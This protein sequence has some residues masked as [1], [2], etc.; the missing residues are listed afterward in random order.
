MQRFFF[1][2]GLVWAVTVSGVEAQTANAGVSGQSRASA[3]SGQARVSAE[4][5]QD[6]DA[7]VNRKGKSADAGADARQQGR[8]EA[9]AGQQSLNLDAGTQINA[10]LKSTLDSRQA[11]DGQQFLLKTARDVKAG[12]RTV[13]RKGAT[14]VG[15]VV[16]AQSKAEGE[17][18]SSLTVMIDGVRQGEETIPLQ[19]VFV[20]V[21]QQAAQSSVD[22]DLG[23]AMAGAEPPRR[24]SGGGLLGGGGGLVGGVTGAVGGTVDSTV[25]S[26]VGA[27]TRT[28][29]EVSGVGNVGSSVG[30]VGSSV[31]GVGSAVSG[32]GRTLF[33]LGGGVTATASGSLS[34]ATEFTRSGKDLKL[35]KGTE[36]VLAVTGGGQ[37]GADAGRR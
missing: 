14:L 5:K 7:R 20:G 33:T 2:I 18:R 35:E 1:A 24:G 31:G 16:S 17:G 37:V 23:G 21:V 3:Q 36:F 29:G 10:V 19:A 30:N 6:A 32:A 34:G 22:S 9:D 4:T 28:V 25:G 11:A 13:I 12:G 8:V 26:T 15:H 27:T